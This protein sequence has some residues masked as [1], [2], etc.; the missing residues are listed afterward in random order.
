MTELTESAGQGSAERAELI[1]KST[2]DQVSTPLH[3]GGVVGGVQGLELK[4]RSYGVG[5]LNAALEAAETR[6]GPLLGLHVRFTFCFGCVG[7]GI[8][9]K[10]EVMTVMNGRADVILAAGVFRESID[11]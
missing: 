10:G 4:Y 9:G 5:H 11:L 8:A 6:R 7:A 1:G 3:F 2:S